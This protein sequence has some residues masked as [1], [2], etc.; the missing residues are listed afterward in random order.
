[1]FDRPGTTR[2][3]SH[4][5]R[6]REHARRAVPGP[7]L[8][9]CRHRESRIL[10]RWSLFGQEPL[11]PTHRRALEPIR[12]ALPIEHAQAERVLQAE[13]AKLARGVLGATQ[14]AILQRPGEAAVSGSLRRP[15]P[16]SRWGVGARSL[17][18][19][20]SAAISAFIGGRLRRAP[21][22][23]RRCPGVALDVAGNATFRPLRIGG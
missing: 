19:G 18:R 5:P 9:Q 20:Y 16:Q 13:P 21:A 14:V 3:A 2:L 6:E 4:E 11:E 7:Q 22:V 23:R 10:Q 17:A 8:G 1:V 15:S 12:R